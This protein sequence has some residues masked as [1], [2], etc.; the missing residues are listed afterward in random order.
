M[1]FKK[2]SLPIAIAFFTLLQAAAVAATLKSFDDGFSLNVPGKW[3]STDS[4]DPSSVLLATKGQAEIKIR[5]LPAPADDKALIAKLQATRKKLKKGGVAVPAAI[6]TA[7][8][9]EGGKIFFIQ[10]PSKGKK[11]H[12]GF[13]NLAGQSYGFLATGLSGAEFKALAGSLAALPEA[14]EPGAEA[15]AKPAQTAASLPPAEKPGPE[16]AAAPAQA[17][18]QPA[19]AADTLTAPP[20]D[21]SFAAGGATSQEPADLPPL[22]KRNV[23]GS[24]SLVLIAVVLSAGALGYR[25]FAGKA[26]EG[27]EVKAN[28]GSLFPFRVERRYFSFP[29]IFDIKDAAGQQYKAVSPRV[30]ALLLGTGVVAYFLTNALVQLLAFAGVSVENIPSIALLAVVGILSLAKLLI[31]L[32]VILG[33]FFRT[34]LKVYDASGN[35]VL[36]VCQKRLTFASL[37]FIIRDPAGNELGKMKR[38]GFVFIRRHWQLL[39]AEDKVL[40]DIREDSVARAFA[41]RLLGHLWGLL[42]TSYILSDDN[43]EIGE[44]KRDWSIWNRYTLDVQGLN[45]LPDPRLVM[46]TSL[47]VDII[48]P[49]RWHPWHG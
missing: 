33:M 37:F 14:E 45:A 18:L 35:L 20:A 41:R 39:G 32:G 46:A 47:F 19:P 21:T 24:L 9:G 49:D 30:P 29:I 7:A 31:F 6:S 3:Q 4:T 12:S 13:F 10:F 48:D 11:Y 15:Q 25:A 42:R 1:T 34:K 8:T 27:P 38:A 23:G 16:P 44:L 43:G 36:D 28:P 2:V 40:L 22:P 26:Q 17:E 5:V